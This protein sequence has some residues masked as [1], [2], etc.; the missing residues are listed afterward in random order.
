MTLCAAGNVIAGR[1]TID[2][3]CYFD[4]KCHQGSTDIY[5]MVLPSDLKYIINHPEFPY[6]CIVVNPHGNLTTRNFNKL[7]FKYAPVGYLSLH[8]HD[9]H[10]AAME[11]SLIL[12]N[13][14]QILSV[15]L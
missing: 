11:L 3:V 8:I 1:V 5:N 15:I 2:F 9:H 13:A 6:L 12:D 14:K 7:R 4:E 10:D